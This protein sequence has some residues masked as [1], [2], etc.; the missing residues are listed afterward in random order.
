MAFLNDSKQSNNCQLASSFS[1]EK[2]KERSR[3]NSLLSS[4]TKFTL[5]FRRKSHSDSSFASK[6]DPEENGFLKQSFVREHSK[7]NT[8]EQLRKTLF[9][10]S[11]EAKFEHD[12]KSSAT[13]QRCFS[14][15]PTHFEN[16]R[17]MSSSDILSALNECPK[18]V[19][20]NLSPKPGRPPKI[21][22]RSYSFVDDAATGKVH[23]HTTLNKCSSC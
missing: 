8:E 9:R 18:K 5:Q 3:S 2:R 10:R 1:G 15:M 11:M 17:I 4:L 7:R 13:L 19:D 21:F 12:H 6:S 22:M 20:L 23:Q 14:E 16:K